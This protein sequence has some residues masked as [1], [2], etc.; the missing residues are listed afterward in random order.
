MAG[1]TQVSGSSVYNEDCTPPEAAG[2]APADTGD[3]PPLDMDG[4]LDGCWYTYVSDAKENPSGTY[5]ET[6]T[7]LFVGCLNGTTCRSSRRPTR[8]PASSRRASKRSTDAAS[9]RSRARQAALPECLASSSSRM[10][11]ILGSSTT[12]Q[13]RVLVLHGS[14][15]PGEPTE[16]LG[17]I[18]QGP[19]QPVNSARPPLAR[20]PRSAPG[21]ARSRDRASQTPH[22]LR[23][24]MQTL[25]EMAEG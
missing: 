18:S 1:T 15:G 20:A 4:S 11:S 2:T 17:P 25:D 8:S 14:I 23:Q 21:E 3:Y 24:P 19:A 22:R 10:T 6:G 16:T 7:E 5:K 13:H 12:G 9:T